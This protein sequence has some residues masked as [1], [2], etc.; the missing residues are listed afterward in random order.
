MQLTMER[1]LSVKFCVELQKSRSE[2]LE[3]LKT[4]YGES[5]MGKRNIILWQKCFRRGRE[6][7]KVSESQ[8]ASV[9][10]RTD[11]NEARVK[12]T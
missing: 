5:A 2:T 10:K 12:G 11:E 4:V 3:T 9:T 7:V 6:S 1:R 8:A